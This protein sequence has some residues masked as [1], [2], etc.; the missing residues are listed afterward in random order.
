MLSFIRYFLE[1][2]HF[3]CITD[4][5]GAGVVVLVFTSPCALEGLEV[6]ESLLVVGD[7]SL[8]LFKYKQMIII[9][10]TEAKK[11]IKSSSRTFKIKE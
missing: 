7:V 4:S 2:V 11:T 5:N 8:I 3:V 9:K 1:Y 6:L 10:K